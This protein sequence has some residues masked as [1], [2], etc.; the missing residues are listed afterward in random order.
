VTP[1]SQDLNLTN[2][3]YNLSISASPFNLNLSGLLNLT[4]QSSEDIK[5]LEFDVRYYQNFEALNP[6]EHS[7]GFYIFKTQ[8]ATNESVPFNHNVSSIMAYK[9]KFMQ[10]FLIGY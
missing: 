8:N 1:T 10:M 3:F 9:G 6:E 7:G 2:N 5:R 4:L